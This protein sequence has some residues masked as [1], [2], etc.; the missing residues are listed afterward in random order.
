M[1]LL[2]RPLQRS[3][4]DGHPPE[5]AAVYLCSPRVPFFDLAAGKARVVDRP[6]DRGRA[7]FDVGF[8][9]HC[10]HRCWLAG[11]GVVGFA[12]NPN[13]VHIEKR[14]GEAGWNT[15]PSFFEGYLS[16]HSAADLPL[17]RRG[18]LISWGDFVIDQ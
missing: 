16:S 15:R 12:L 2:R 3:K 9:F 17:R 14:D 1:N 4:K 8:D 10:I 5:R 13:R 7:G 18:D 6:V 11:L